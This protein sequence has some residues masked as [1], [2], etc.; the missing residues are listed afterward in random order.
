[1]VIERCFK[2]LPISIFLS[3]V[4]CYNYLMIEKLPSGKLMF[5]NTLSFHKIFSQKYDETNF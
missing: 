4:K 5:Q 3:C 1:M 2:I